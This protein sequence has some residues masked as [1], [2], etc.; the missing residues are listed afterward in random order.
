MIHDGDSVS[1]VFLEEVRLKIPKNSWKIKI[2]AILLRM[3]FMVSGKEYFTYEDIADICDYKDRRNVNNYYREFK[4]KGEDLITYLTRKVELSTY[5]GIIEELVLNN[6]FLNLSELYALF[7]SKYP[8]VRISFASFLKYLS[9]IN[10]YLVIKKFQQLTEENSSSWKENH[11]I[12]Y[13]CENIDNPIVKKKIEDITI[14]T[15]TKKQKP[16]KT[17][18]NIVNQSKSFF[19]KFL[20]GAGVSYQI[21][22]FLL[23][24]SKS[25]VNKYV[26]SSPN[27]NQLILSSIERYSGKVCVDEKYIKLNGKT[28]YIFS[29]VDNV[30]GIPLLVGIFEHKTAESWKSFLTIFKKHYGNP[31]LFISDGCQSLASARKSVFPEVPFQYCKFHKMRNFIKK[32]YENEKDQLKI[33]KIITKLK[34]VFSR[35]TTDARRKALLEL[36]DITSGEVKNYLCNRIKAHWKHLLK[37]LTSNAAERWNRKIEKIVSGKYGLKSLETILQ[38]IC[39]LWFKELIIRGQSHLSKESILSKIKINDSCQEIID[40]DRL[41][42]FSNVNKYKKGA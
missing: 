28:H 39:C 18:P 2:L 34:Q 40:R 30:K 41:N 26:Y 21:I 42:G 29:V 22:S 20:V 13:L 37:S 36:E 24:I 38:L 16:D 10:A 25:T 5:V 8:D 15:K 11:L 12:S 19:I 31:K 7:K 33:N 32:L 1:I 4:Q 14:E 9:Q 27:F 6:L 17:K 23:G 35:E 3:F